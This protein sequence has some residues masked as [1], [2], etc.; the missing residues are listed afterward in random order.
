MENEYPLGLKV[1]NYTLNELDAFTDQVVDDHVPSVFFGYSLGYI[2]LFKKYPDL[3]QVVNDFDFMLCDGVPFNWFLR[4]I[5]VKLKTVMSIPEFCD[6]M[7]KKCNR[8]R[9]S[10]MIIGGTEEI[11]K[12]ATENLR[13]K[14]SD[15]RWIDGKNGYFNKEES[16]HIIEYVNQHEPDVLMIAM[17]TPLKEEFV[18]KYKGRLKASIIIPCGGM[19]DVF[20]GRTNKSPKW[21]KKMGLAT[22]YRIAQEPRRL[23]IHHMKMV[24]EGL[25][26][27]IPI[28]WWNVFVKRKRGVEVIKSYVKK[29]L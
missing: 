21:I 24:G 9:W 5:G 16:E 14:Y 28:A 22:F 4:S 7:V 27:F 25:F 26:K 15:A 29:E 2:T 3:F 12:R 8:K 23:L 18:L 1:T 11:N 10:C 6:W 20:A 19:V 13:R 17:S